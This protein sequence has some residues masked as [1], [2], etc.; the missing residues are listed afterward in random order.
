M[1]RALCAYVAGRELSRAT[2]VKLRHRLNCWL[3]YSPQSDAAGVTA[4]AFD[5]FRECALAAG[6]SKRT[7]EETVSDVSRLS[8]CRDLGN[9]LRRW[10]ASPCRSVPTL[11]VLGRAYSRADSA[12]WPDRRL[13]RTDAFSRFTAGDFLRAFLVFGYFTGL[14]LRDLRSVTWAAYDRGFTWTASKTGRLHVFPECQ[15]VERHL[16]PLRTSGDERIFPLSSDQEYLLRRE[17]K[18][19]SGSETFGPQ[20]MRRCSVTQWTIADHRAGDLIQGNGLGVMARYLGARQVLAA[21][22]PRLA[23]PDEFLTAAERDQRQAATLRLAK[24]V[25]RIPLEKLGD[26]ERVAAAFAG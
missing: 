19:I 4:A 1:E 12:S 9:R 2:S 21:A 7:I 15:I 23:W 25:G 17:L 5:A 20:A 16:R 24:I 3:K 18:A 11:E 10:K 13:C 22:M 8:G 14:R 6:L 26:L